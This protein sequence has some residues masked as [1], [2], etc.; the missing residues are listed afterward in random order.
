[1]STEPEITLDPAILAKLQDVAAT[2]C[3]EGGSYECV[4][5]NNGTVSKC[6]TS[7]AVVTQEGKCVPTQDAP[8][9]SFYETV[10]NSNG[11]LEQ[12]HVFMNGDLMQFRNNG[13]GTQLREKCVSVSSGNT[14]TDDNYKLVGAV[15]SG[16][17][18]RIIN[19]Y[20][21]SNSYNVDGNVDGSC[22]SGYEWK[23]FNKVSAF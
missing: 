5:N 4:I 1:M 9:G 7:R 12:T 21:Y 22:P 13:H 10:Y 20:K 8:D 2:Q 16:M 11:Q 3:P 17:Q 19:C 14:C 6:S 15:S 23:M 18:G